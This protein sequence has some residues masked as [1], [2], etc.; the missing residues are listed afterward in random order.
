M[1]RP[2]WGSE[3][4]EIA[5]SKKPARRP[6]SL[7]SDRATTPRHWPYQT[8]T[9]PSLRRSV[10]E[11]LQRQRGRPGTIQLKETKPKGKPKTTFG[12]LQVELS[13]SPSYIAQ[14]STVSPVHPNRRR[15]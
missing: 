6:M 7:A 9:L 10:R 2:L 5:S 1:L 3:D 8:R 13:R 15:V 14:A 11:R 4:V 12:N